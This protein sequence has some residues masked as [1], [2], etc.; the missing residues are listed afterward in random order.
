MREAGAVPEI[1]TSQNMNE[2]IKKGAGEGR[3]RDVSVYV[4]R[5]SV[6]SGPEFQNRSLDAGCPS[7]IE[8]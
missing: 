3:F 8:I 1:F 2:L 6:F 7:K 4:A 5:F